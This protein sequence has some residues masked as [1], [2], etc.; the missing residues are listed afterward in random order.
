MKTKDE[1]PKLNPVIYEEAADWIV[2]LREGE[3]DAQMRERLDAWFRTSPEHIRAYLEL[4][5]IWEEGADPDLDRAHTTDDLIALRRS[6]HNVVA[7]STGAHIGTSL[8]LPETRTGKQGPNDVVPN[9]L[10]HS[11]KHY[12]VL[13]ERV[14]L[15]TVNV[16]DT[17]FVSPA[18]RVTVDKLGKGFFAI[19]FT[20]GFFETPDI[21]EA[22]NLARAHGLALEMDS[23]TFFSKFE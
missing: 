12:K 4:S 23:A 15:A 21:P 9:A 17:P 7:L 11:L 5:S 16:V 10:L 19:R 13:H 18:R 20:Y 2:E 14:V 3:V 8:Q 22:L 6:P 1:K